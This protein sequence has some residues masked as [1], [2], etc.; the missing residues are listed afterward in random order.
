MRVR[1]EGFRCSLP[2]TESTPT[3][4]GTSRQKFNLA[5][6]FSAVNLGVRTGSKHRAGRSSCR[7][8]HNV[9]RDM[10]SELCRRSTIR[11]CRGVSV[12]AVSI[13]ARTSLV[14]RRLSGRDSSGAPRRRC[15]SFVLML[16]SDQS[17]CIARIARGFRPSTPRLMMQKFPHVKENIKNCLNNHYDHHRRDGQH[18]CTRRAAQKSAPDNYSAMALVT[19]N[20]CGNNEKLVRNEQQRSNQQQQC[21]SRRSNS[22]SDNTKQRNKRPQPKTESEEEMRQRNERERR[23]GRG[24]R[25]EV[26]KN[27]VP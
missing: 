12:S 7:A 2:R 21:S 13:S 3:R 10:S 4:C 20:T 14:R 5:K 8:G 1:S 11:S 6:R 25:G 27:H 9:E 18:T 17:G 24:E 19:E 26:M 16:S 15:L 22:S 23:R